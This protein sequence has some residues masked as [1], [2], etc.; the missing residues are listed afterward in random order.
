MFTEVLFARTNRQ[1]R[2]A[3][4]RSHHQPTRG[5]NQR[6]LSVSWPSGGVKWLLLVLILTASAIL[7]L[8]NLD[9]MPAGLHVDEAANAWNAYCLLKTG[10]DQH[11]VHWPVFYLR[12]FGDNRSSL[13]A[14]ALLPI[15][16]IGGL[17]VWTTRL[18]AVLGGILTVFLI[19]WVGTK[20]F[21]GRVGLAAAAMLALNPWHLQQSRWGHEAS[22]VP[23]LTLLPV[24]VLLW[25]QLPFRGG[26]NLQFQPLKAALA[27][28]VIGICCYGY[29]AV[30][31]F[32][33][34]FLVAV[35]I[36]SWGDWWNQLKTYRGMMASILLILSLAAT[37]GPLLWKHLTDPEINKRAIT[38]QV[39]ADSDS[40][41]T[42]IQKV[43]GRYPGHFGLDFLFLNGDKDIALSP[44][45][46]TGLFLWDSIVWMILGVIVLFKTLVTSWA[47][48]I[49][50][51]WLIT[52]PVGDLLHHHVSLHSLRSLPGLCALVLLAALG[53]IHAG[54]WLWMRDRKV[55]WIVIFLVT[56][57]VAALNA[58]FLD[59]FY[60]GFYQSPDKQNVLYADDLL[61]ASQWLKPQ[62]SGAEAVFCT[63]R[64]IAH[65]YIYTLIGM[66]YDPGQWLRDQRELVKGPLANGDYANEE[67]CVSYGKMHFIV[68]EFHA[69]A[70][71]RLSKNN[72]SD[73]VIFIVRPGEFGLENKIRPVQ[74]I[75]DRLGRKSLLVFDG[76]L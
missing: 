57:V 54:Q 74:V 22:L 50:A 60:R 42:R 24:T 35:L 30:R 1:Q 39:W 25:A 53:M 45:P 73:R 15:Q 72:S 62:L 3:Q 64:M 36:V 75:E 17:S 70:L 76:H 29:P 61:K 23:L 68:G 55:R 21:G 65:P 46:Q 41:G 48:R 9:E 49:L 14:Y 66:Q 43:L 12:A 2:T 34:V 32:L 7:R 44:P 16:A 56:S 5:K 8:W 18:L 28:A 13:F 58:R 4:S 63:S 69:G 37:L 40:L 51:V 59:R 27:G 52:Y 31:V 47:S 26:L 71:D 20:L 67:E 10:S 33:P 11:G 6:V 38:T 19:Y